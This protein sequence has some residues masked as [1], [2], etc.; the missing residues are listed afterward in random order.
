MI[1]LVNMEKSVALILDRL[2]VWRGSGQASGRGGWWL[3]LEC[4]SGINPS[5]MRC[6]RLTWQVLNTPP[7]P[8]PLWRCIPV[9]AD[10]SQPPSASSR[11]QRPCGVTTDSSAEREELQRSRSIQSGLWE[12]RDG[13]RGDRGLHLRRSSVGFQTAGRSRAAEA[14]TGGKGTVEEE[15]KVFPRCSEILKQLL[16]EVYGNHCRFYGH[17]LRAKKV[18]AK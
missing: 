9:E 16:F 14:S 11:V 4:R 3:F 17:C 5:W 12:R 8:P 1:L 15:E 13:G 10:E 2:P 18:L 7:S 6:L